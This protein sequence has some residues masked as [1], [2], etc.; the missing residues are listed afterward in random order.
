VQ[1]WIDELSNGI[2]AVAKAQARLIQV[3]LKVSQS[4]LFV[5]GRGPI[6]M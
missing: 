4:G 3:Q 2:A 5:L 1:H 6:Q